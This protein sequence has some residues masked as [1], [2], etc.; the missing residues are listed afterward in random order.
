MQL[1]NF[2]QPSISTRAQ[3]SEQWNQAFALE[4]AQDEIELLREQIA[5]VQQYLCKQLV[6]TRAVEQELQ[7][8]EKELERMS[9][10]NQ[11]L[12]MENQQ[13]TE[14][15]L[16]LLQQTKELARALSAQRGTD[17]KALMKLLNN[18]CDDIASFEELSIESNLDYAAAVFS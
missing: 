11:Q 4:K 3:V 9:I 7:E 1:F 6:Q 5:S 10:E 2:D 15:K 18:F 17:R 8:T 13:L 14:A 16:M 12:F